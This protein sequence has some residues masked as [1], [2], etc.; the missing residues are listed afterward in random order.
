[1]KE[2]IIHADKVSYETTRKTKV[3][4]EISK[5]MERGEMKDVIWVR[6]AA[7]KSDE[8]DLNGIAQQAVEDLISVS[9]QV[10]CKN[11]ML[12]PYAHLL[13]GSTPASPE[14]A[15]QVLKD[16]EGALKENGFNV[17]RAPFGYYKK[18]TV[19]A[20]GHPLSE[21]SR[22]FSTSGKAEKKETEVKSVDAGERV[23]DSLKKEAGLK[24]RFYVLTPDG[25]L[26]EHG[27]FNYTGHEGL[28]KFMEYET[29]KVRAY[30]KE[31]PH[32]K[33]MKEHE[34]VD[35][36]PGTDQGNF[37]WYPNGRLIKKILEKSI[38]D[39]CVDYGAMEVE[40]PVM[41][42]FEHPTLKKYLDRFP[43]RQYVVLSDEKKLFLRFA[44]CFGQ[45]LMA[46]GMV[47]SHRHLPLKMYELTRY[48]FRREQGGELAGLKRLRAFTM[49]DMHAFC[50]D[51]PQ[52]Q[53]EFERQLGLG[54]S[55]LSSVGL[56]DEAEVGFRIETA[57]YEKNKEWY[58]R[59]VKKIGKPVLVE[60]FDERYAYFITKFE[61]NFIDSMD[62]ASALTTV[63]IDVENADTYGINYV[64]EDGSK[65]K[66]VITHA[67]ISGSL[68]RVVYA[69][70]EK[71]GMRMEKGEKALLPL[72]LSPTQVRIIPISE[73]HMEYAGKLFSS[74]DG[75]RADIDDRE[76]SLGKKIR[77]VEKDW[78]PYVAVVGDKEMEAGKLSVTIRE[79]GAKKEMAAEELAAEIRK[80]TEGKPFEQLSL[81]KELSLRP[82]FY[83]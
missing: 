83:G 56:Y 78:V 41:Y 28:H 22:V 35:Y 42:D 15:L 70:L 74:F 54:I 58:A 77:Q 25:K 31:P 33:I 47:I 34:F 81:P 71:E 21:L 5:E 51:I 29:K 44:A 50:R 66:P 79:T 60:M 2:L 36:E 55:W 65:K 11:V 4:E 40:T 52:S 10:K 59:M 82:I 7:E 76:E 18:F 39:F 13:F 37:R 69:L 72:W 46:T 24:S 16:M 17:V 63:Q 23:S 75:V 67:S 1:M 8:E 19:Y 64:D 62:K 3:A 38:T 43:A 73:K 9:E 45:F 27:K 68:E 26:V 12:Y 61:F 80:K 53:E 14:A 49:P 32:I 57:F 20:K 6:I 48:S 30:E